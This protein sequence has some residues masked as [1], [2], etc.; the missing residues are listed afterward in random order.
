MATILDRPQSAL[1]LHTPTIPQRRPVTD[2]IDVDLLDSDDELETGRRVRF[3]REPS[4]EVIQVSE[5]EDEDVI[6]VAGGPINSGGGPATSAPAPAT[7]RNRNRLF[8]PPPRLNMSSTSIPPVPRLAPH[9]ASQASLPLFRH[10]PHPPHPPH[11]NHRVGGAG[12]SPS[13]SS[14]QPPVRAHDRPFGFEDAFNS[15][16]A[17]SSGSSRSHQLSPST[18]PSGSRVSSRSSSPVGLPPR[19]GLGGALISSNNARLAEERQMASRRRLSAVQ[20]A[21]E[22]AHARTLRAVARTNGHRGDWGFGGLGGGGG[23]FGNDRDQTLA[24]LYLEIGLMPMEWPHGFLDPHQSKRT[25]VEYRKEYTHPQPAE[26]GFTFD[27]ATGSSEDG[28]ESLSEGS[29]HPATSARNPIIID[30]DDQEGR[31]GV[32]SSST[33]ENKGKERATIVESSSSPLS[34]RT[35]LVCSHCRDPLLLGESASKLGPEGEGARRIWSLRC[36]HLIDGK[37]LEVLSTPPSTSASSFSEQGQSSSS[38]AHR[39]GKGKAIAPP[40]TGNE[41]EPSD[42]RARLRSRRSY[43]PSLP[44]LPSLMTG[45]KDAKEKE[46]NEANTIQETFA[47][48]CPVGGCNRQHTSVR[49]RGVWGPAKPEM[50]KGDGVIGVFV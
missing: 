8:S 30:D 44:S 50:G 29:Q 7:T 13:S 47:W 10:P 37:C 33:I 6:P 41:S 11:S 34:L 31:V 4:V 39:K 36:G 35:L 18:R 28:E 1:L 46:T 14:V 2:I 48:E 21:R 27:F 26:A 40:E 38:D 49:I 16:R 23:G 20:R 9:L 12:Y 43:I 5:D 3:R 45:R 25:E 17:S 22:H 19:L 24:H 32:G 15:P 42:Y